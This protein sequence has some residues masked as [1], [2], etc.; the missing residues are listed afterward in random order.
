[1]IDSYLALLNFCGISKGIWS[2]KYISWV[3][4]LSLSEILSFDMLF[5][6]FKPDKRGH[7][8]CMVVGYNYLCNQCLS[9]LKLQVRTSLMARYTRY[10]D[11]WSSL[12]VTC[13]FSQGTP[14]FSTNKTDRHDLSY[15]TEILLKEVLNTINLSSPNQMTLCPDTLNNYSLK[16]L[17]I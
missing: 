5:K 17:L 10:I 14:V 7:C 3:K 15:I 11:M 13:W 4:F 9:P 12:W 1:V 8:N 16:Y 2:E 6:K